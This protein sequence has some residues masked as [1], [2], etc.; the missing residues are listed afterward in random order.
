MSDQ[1]MCM[2]SMMLLTLLWEGGR[3]QMALYIESY[4][5]SKKEGEDRN[6]MHLLPI[7]KLMTALIGEERGEETGWFSHEFQEILDVFRN[8]NTF[9]P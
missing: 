1:K 7:G 2:C 6:Q 5:D 8:K 9:K 4:M 3:V